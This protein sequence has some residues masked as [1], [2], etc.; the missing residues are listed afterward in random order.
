[1]E[2][3]KTLG[4]LVMRL[5]LC[6]VA[7]VFSSCAIGPLMSFETARTLG[8][9]HHEFVGGYGQAG[10]AFK[11]NFGVSENLDFGLQQ[12]AFSFGFR[13]K[14]SFINQKTAGFSFAG[15]VGV[16]GNPGGSHQYGDLLFSYLDEAWE[17]YGTLRVVHVNVDAVDFKDENTGRTTFRFP[18]N[19]F[20]YGEAMLG[21]RYWFNPQW[22]LSVEA[23]K[24]FALSTD[25]TIE[26]DVLA[27]AGLGYRF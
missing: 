16:G 20:T 14:Y 3:L 18:E 21:T 6:F 27:G 11:W 22:S 10:A 7:L 26:G 17:P 12:E 23:A 8:R 5:S 2:P 9:G 13:A 25:L 4:A 15:A 1:M 24:V 19:E